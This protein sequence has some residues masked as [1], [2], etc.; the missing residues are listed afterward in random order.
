MLMHEKPCLIPIFKFPCNCHAIPSIDF[1]ENG[2][3][4]I[5]LINS[6]AYSYRPVSYSAVDF[7]RFLAGSMSEPSHAAYT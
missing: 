4:L 5:F 7:L 6:I 2:S 1:N 3:Q